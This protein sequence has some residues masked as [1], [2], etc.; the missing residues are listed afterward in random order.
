MHI[1]IP[2]RCAYIHMCTCICAYV[3]VNLYT[4]AE[5][6]VRGSR[7]STSGVFRKVAVVIINSDKQVQLIQI[8][9]HTLCVSYV[10]V[11]SGE[12]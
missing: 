12:R 1:N 8:A 6:P 11:C 7:P 9:R 4:F 2:L 10:C 5:A 3:Y